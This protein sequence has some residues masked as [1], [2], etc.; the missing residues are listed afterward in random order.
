MKTFKTK[1]KNIKFWKMEQWN[2]EKSKTGNIRRN[3]K[4]AN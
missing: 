3:E 2:I 1:N 4:I